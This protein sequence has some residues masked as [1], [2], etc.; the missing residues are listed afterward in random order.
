MKQG[1]IM[2]LCLIIIVGGGIAEIK[3]LEN[4]SNYLKA[5]INYIDNMIENENYEEALNQIEIV[6]KNWYNTEMIWNIFL[7]NDEIDDLTEALTELKEYI[8]YEN[9]EE[10]RI[11]I[12]K[13]KAYSELVVRRQRIRI[14]NIL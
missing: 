6:D 5:D 3:Y 12:E 13:L 7:I 9:E 8:E 11:A 1:I 4:T 10:C 2:F 14:D